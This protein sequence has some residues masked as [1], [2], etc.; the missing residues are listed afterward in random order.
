MKRNGVASI[1]EVTFLVNLLFTTILSDFQ[2]DAYYNLNSFLKKKTNG[3]GYEKSFPQ[4]GAVI[5]HN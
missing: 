4:D 5:A 1:Y 3:F 2:T